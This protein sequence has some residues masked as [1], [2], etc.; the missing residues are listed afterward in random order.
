MKIDFLLAVARTGGVEK[1]INRYTEYL[2]G[3]GHSIRLIQLVYEGDEWFC[4]PDCFYPLL[5]G[6]AGHNLSEF[7]NAYSNFL[8][9]N[10][11]PDIILATAWPYMS[12]IGKQA[13]TN[14]D[15]P[16]IPV[17]SW[18]HAPAEE[19]A[20][21]GYGGYDFLSY[22]DAHFAI[23]QY[24][25]Q[26]IMNNIPAAKIIDVY[27]PIDIP[28]NTLSSHDLSYS[29]LFVGRL[30]VEKKIDTIIK[31]MAKMNH[32]E[33]TLTVVGDGDQRSSLV[34]LARKIG[35]SD[36]INWVGWQT[37]PWAYG[38]KAD[39]VILSSAYEGFPLTALEALAHGIP[40]ISTPVSGIAE[41]IVPG[42]NGFLFGHDDI[43]MLWQLLDMYY[44]KKFPTILPQKCRESVM[45]YDSKI[46]F[47]DF[48]DKLLLM[49]RN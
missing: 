31:A 48:E 2:N 20:R 1:L 3:N 10:D 44:D 19:Y 16:N 45:Q 12:Y 7:V 36:R 18:M 26:G 40:V 17:I 27:N 24:I 11:M 37:D 29:I 30:S 38:E 4:L 23:S 8:K 14:N 33:V 21:A 35:V 28:D 43:D 46:S 49:S 34:S 39:F 25:R 13:T 15:C 32:K 42:A 22:A 5:K 6:R 47:K 41:I 9:E